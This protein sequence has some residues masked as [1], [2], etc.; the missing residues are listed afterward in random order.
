VASI[1]KREEIIYVLGQED[2]PVTL[3]KHSPILHLMQQIRDETHR[4]AVGFHRQRRSAR[5][6]HSELTEIAGIGERTAQKLLRR[7]G[8]VAR[9]KAASVDE[10]ARIVTK[11]Q[12]AKIVAHFQGG[13]KRG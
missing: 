6:I 9:V 2:E 4:F 12:A 8:S 7:F 13:E 5:T 11:P 1:A 10:L 3:E